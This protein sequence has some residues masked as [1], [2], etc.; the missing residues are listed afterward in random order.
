MAFKPYCC[1]CSSWHW[2][3]EQHRQPE[4]ET[5]ICTLCAGLESPDFYTGC[6]VQDGHVTDWQC[7]G[8]G[9]L[10]RDKVKS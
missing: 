9:N 3:Y 6:M 8:K 4:R 1:E 10:S 7:D 2:T 5:E